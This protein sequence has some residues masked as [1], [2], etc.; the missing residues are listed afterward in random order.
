M[1][2]LVKQSTAVVNFVFLMVDS[3]DHV[4]GKT[5]LTPTVTLSK[6]GAA[7]AA[8]S[9]AVTEI[10]SGWYKLAANATDSNT[11]GLLALHATGTGA[12]P[13]DMI[14]CEV[15][16]FDPQ[17]AVRAGLTAMPNAAAGT[18]GGLPLSVDA[19][20]RVDVLKINGTSQTAGDVTALLTAIKA[21]ADQFVFTVAN[22][23]DANALSGGGSLPNVYTGVVRAGSTANTLNLPASFPSYKCLPGSIID[24]TSATGIG[25]SVTVLSTSGMGGATPV[26]TLVSGQT[27][28]IATPAAGDAFTIRTMGGLVPSQVQ[29]V[30]DDTKC[31]TRGVNKV[32]THS[33]QD[34]GIGDTN[35][36]RT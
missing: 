35:I 14:L 9:G 8:A 34:N 26:A 28:P 17:D 12:D 30:W 16:A 23:V 6:N 22:Q 25:Q 3:A 20:G 31:P 11:L 2:A 7:F 5:G 4:T 19:S 13:T 15:I 29:D 27:W 33:L 10:S 21:K 1:P 36:G 32:G 24:I 18:N